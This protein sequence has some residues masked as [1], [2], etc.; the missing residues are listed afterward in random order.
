MISEIWHNIIELL[1]YD[2]SRPMLFSSGLFWALFLV[3]MPLYGLLKR[4][5]WQ[6]SVFV[7]AFSLYFYYKSS[8]MF[9]LMLT[10]TSLL[11]WLL[12][13]IMSQPEASPA[14][15]RTCLAIS[16]TTSLGILAY[17]KYADFFLWNPQCHYRL[18]FSTTRPDT[19]CRHIV[20]Y[21]QSVSYIIDIYKRRVTPTATWL[22][23][24]FFLSFFPALVAGPIVRADYFLPQIRSNR[25]A[26][27]KEVYSGLWM[28]ITGVV[29]KR[30]SPIT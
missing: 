6:M 11:D 12:S 16:L 21:L 23:Y 5:W 24:A 4:R 27:R 29:K 8:G 25:H 17:F 20:L 1:S 10:G 22:E 13:I 3:F 28:I 7:V 19:A 15:R 26:S 9:V 14:Q 30:L 18:E 2:S